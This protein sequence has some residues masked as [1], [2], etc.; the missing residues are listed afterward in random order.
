MPRIRKA[1]GQMHGFPKRIHAFI[2]LLC[3]ELDRWSVLIIKLALSVAGFFLVLKVVIH[4][5]LG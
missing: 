2:V 3:K 4:I 1:G 5:L